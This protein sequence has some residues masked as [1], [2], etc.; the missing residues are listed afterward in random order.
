MALEEFPGIERLDDLLFCDCRH[1]CWDGC[2]KFDLKKYEGDLFLSDSVDTNVW[3][4][5][6]FTHSS[7]CGGGLSPSLFRT[8]S[9]KQ[10]ERD[11][12]AE[13]RAGE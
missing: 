10:R 7:R 5:L 6:G 3:L 1:K 8:E 13:R 2:L 9:E 4:S 12:A 11:A